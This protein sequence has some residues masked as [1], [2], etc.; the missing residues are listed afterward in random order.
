LPQ[1][2]SQRFSLQLRSKGQAL[3]GKTG[4]DELR[5]AR[6][7]PAPRGLSSS[8]TDVEDQLALLVDGVEGY[9]VFL[10]DSKGR[11]ATWNL[12]AE[13]ILG[14][15]GEEALGQDL[16]FL[17]P[18]PST[19]EPE[20]ALED[21]LR[22]G[23]HQEDAWRRK[24]DGSLAW[25][26]TVLQPLFRDDE[27][28]G[29]GVILR[30]DTETKK[31]QDEAALAREL[32]LA[33]GAAPTVDEALDTALRK[34]C[35]ATG[36]NLGEAWIR[37][38]A[39]LECS[40]AWYTDTPRLKRF[41]RDAEGFRIRPGTGLPG[42]AWAERR[43][44]WMRDVI[45]DPRF[46]RFALART[47]GVGAGMA[48]PI[49]SGDEVV[50][51]LVFFVF[52]S[53]EEDAQLIDLVSTIGAQ[54]GALV[55]RKRT[56]DVLSESEARY[57]LLAENATDLISVTT[58]DGTLKYVSP[59]AEAIL[60]YE[61][62]VVVGRRA[63]EFVHP[64][65]SDAVS[66]VYAR[67]LEARGLVTTPPY[68]VRRGDGSY[69]WIESTVRAVHDPESGEL[70]ELQ[71][72]GRDVTE[73]KSAEEAL[74]ES[75]LLK[76]T[77]LRA[78]SHDFRSPLTA[79]MA[80]AEACASPTIGEEGRKELSSV[81]VSQASRLAAL[82]EKLLDLSRL[83]AGQADPRRVW[84]SMEEL[85]DAALEQI[86]G[87]VGLFDLRIEP[88]L[89]NILVDPAQLERAFAN[90]F[91]NARRFAD[92]KAVEVSAENRRGRLVVRVADNGPG[93][94][95]EERERVFEAF[96]RS[97]RTTGQGSGLGLAIVKGFVELNGGR[98]YVEAGARETGT[99]FVVELPLTNHT[100][101]AGDLQPHLA[102]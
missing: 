23:R 88:R 96:Y 25:A 18:A 52:E 24:R 98:V 37:I 66:R 91:E 39:E 22:T 31:L 21:A 74:R 42:I 61:P 29:F 41:R 15:S 90:L 47:F 48:V 5:D 89:P 94:P 100:S 14:Y 85:L 30:D 6:V 7:I 33:I 80:A 28:W 43:P 59:A 55:A 75:D 2:E 95:R 62:E 76:T 72:S 99:T 86:A 68:R 17:Y 63:F 78:V 92:G 53:R 10:L 3:A 102:A 40:P 65:D 34:I 69:V 20:H 60:G 46:L 38:G 81:I 70:V 8:R 84:C 83:E 56:E 44:V 97:E 51:V 36:W 9:A 13:R 73:R 93:I 49:M 27:L 32:A 54:L 71:A 87:D 4:K 35:E 58:P 77:L 57:R 67:V 19:G 64:D 45:S 50:A 16:S 79:I 26:N 101:D 82:V 1:E 12:G 11:V